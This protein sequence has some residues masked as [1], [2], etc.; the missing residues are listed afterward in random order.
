MISNY[1]NV[2]S[3]MFIKEYTFIHKMNY[4]LL[5]RMQ[6][7]EKSDNVGRS[8]DI[9]SFPIKGV[10]KSRITIESLFITKGF[11]E[12]VRNNKTFNTDLEIMSI[13]FNYDNYH[14]IELQKRLNSIE[15]SKVTENIKDVGKRR[16]IF[17]F[18][19]ERN[20]GKGKKLTKKVR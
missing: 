16:S 10:E 18:G 8:I 13:L 9:A 7:I 11:F 2:D 20:G 6:E 17:G 19:R 3:D 1:D 15:S 14:I 5:V 12:T 4:Y